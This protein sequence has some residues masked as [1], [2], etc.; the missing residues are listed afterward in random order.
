[1]KVPSTRHPAG[2]HLRP[3]PFPR[4]D[5][6]EAWAGIRAKAG[7]WSREPGGMQGRS[8]THTPV[9]PPRT[10]AGPPSHWTQLFASRFYFLLA[11]VLFFQA[12]AQLIFFFF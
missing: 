3:V 8:P 12:V 5:G 10:P 9:Q 7:R 1:M 2:T 4:G 6:G 11:C